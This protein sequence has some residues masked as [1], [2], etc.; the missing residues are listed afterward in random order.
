[1]ALAEQYHEKRETAR[2]FK[3][4][5]AYALQ[6]QFTNDQYYLNSKNVWWEKKQSLLE[7]QLRIYSKD[8]HHFLYMIVDEYSGPGHYELKKG[9]IIA[10]TQYGEVIELSADVIAQVEI[11]EETDGAI[12]GSFNIPAMASKKTDSGYR[13][14]DGQFE[15]RNEPPKDVDKSF[16]VR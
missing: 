11:T 1:M 6:D 12:K 9:D 13:I 10:S 8:A 15:A 7:T 2:K 5:I 16:F 14:L 3:G 4:G